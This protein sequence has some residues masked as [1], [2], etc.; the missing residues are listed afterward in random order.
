MTEPTRVYV[1]QG[2]TGSHDDYREWP[3]AAYLHLETA[4]QHCELA[5]GVTAPT[6][7]W[8]LDWGDRQ[9]FIEDTRPLREQLNQHG[10]P[11][12]PKVYVDPYTGTEYVV[13]E[14]PLFRHV[15]EFLERLADGK[16]RGAAP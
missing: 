2:Q 8:N 5:N 12:D 9:A 3:V 14:I 15:D 13:V 4:E 6:V 11:Y 7:R 10:S 1:V 16:Q